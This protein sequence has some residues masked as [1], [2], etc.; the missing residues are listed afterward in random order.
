[1]PTVKATRTQKLDWDTFAHT[2]NPLEPAIEIDLTHCDLLC[3]GP[4]GRAETTGHGQIFELR[5]PINVTEIDNFHIKYVGVAHWDGD[6]EPDVFCLP[7]DGSVYFCA[8]EFMQYDLERVLALPP[9]KFR[10]GVLAT[11]CAYRMGQTLI[12]TAMS[13]IEAASK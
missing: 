8:G 2:T 6:P 1:M 7:D 13:F 12:E 5:T 4:M 9:S 10:E 3:E 11:L